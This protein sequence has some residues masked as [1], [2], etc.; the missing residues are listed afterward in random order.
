MQTASLAI[1]VA[2]LVQSPIEDSGH[3]WIKKEECSPGELL[4]A[5]IELAATAEPE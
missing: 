2:E 4:A 5:M 3:H 1:A